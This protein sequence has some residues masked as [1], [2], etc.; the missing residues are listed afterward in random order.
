VCQ[1]KFA[2]GGKFL[3][4]QS[5]GNVRKEDGK[6]FDEKEMDKNNQKLR[7]WGSWEERSKRVEKPPLGC[8]GGK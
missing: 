5:V 3:N 4:F 6:S 7:K 1:I 8:W 2:K